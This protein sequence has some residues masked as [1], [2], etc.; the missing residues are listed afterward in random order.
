VVGAS[1]VSHACLPRTG[2]ASSVGVAVVTYG[3]AML[4]SFVPSAPPGIVKGSAASGSGRLGL[5]PLNTGPC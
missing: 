2:E 5:G 1:Q 3:E 4:A